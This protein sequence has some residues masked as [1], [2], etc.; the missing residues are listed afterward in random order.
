MHDLCPISPRCLSEPQALPLTLLYSTPGACV[1]D[2]CKMDKTDKAGLDG[3]RLEEVG[4][5]PACAHADL[6][7][8][9]LEKPECAGSLPLCEGVRLGSVWRGSSCLLLGPP[10]SAFQL[11]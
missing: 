5:L 4:R 2:A 9:L 7:K 11:C 6:R 10:T 1:V 3:S 8:R